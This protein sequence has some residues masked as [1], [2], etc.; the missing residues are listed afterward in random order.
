MFGIIVI[1]GGPARPHLSETHT[2]LNDRG[3]VRRAPVRHDKALEAHV[4]L[5]ISGQRLIVL[6]R[7]RAVNLKQSAIEKHIPRPQ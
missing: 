2:R 7:P 5:Q 1:D 3:R 6:A 4:R